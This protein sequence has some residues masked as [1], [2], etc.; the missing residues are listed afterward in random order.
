[1][2]LLKHLYSPIDQVP[3][4]FL[5]HEARRASWGDWDHAGFEAEESAFAV[6][7]D[8]R[9]SLRTVRRRPEECRG[10]RP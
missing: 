5:R 2:K 10:A 8:G 7:S 6:A 1:M 9:V 3:Q 4:R